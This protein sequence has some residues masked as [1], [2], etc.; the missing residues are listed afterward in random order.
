MSG[1]G[2]RLTSRRRWLASVAAGCAGAALGAT[3]DGDPEW[4]EAWVDLSEPVPAGAGDAAEA[5]RRK[6]QVAAQQDRVAAQLRE[7]DVVE[8]AR[9]RHTRNAIEVRLKAA[10]IDAVQRIPGVVRVRRAQVLHPP[11][12]KSGT[13]PL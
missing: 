1:T 10:Q 6:R 11:R 3:S 4:I 7:L 5:R 2:S 9:V 13:E 12:T 8:L